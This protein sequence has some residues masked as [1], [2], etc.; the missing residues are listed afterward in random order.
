[1]ANYHGDFLWYELMSSDREAAEAFYAPLT[2]WKFGSDPAYRHIEASEGHI[3]GLL[4]LTDEMCSHG[5][6]P[7]WLGYIMVDDTDKMAASIEADGGRVTMP[8]RDIEGAGRIAMVTD[9][10]GAHFYVMTPKPPEGVEDPE[11]H[12]FSYDRPRMGHCAWNELSTSDPDAAKRFY[13]KHFGWV[14]DGEMDMGPLGKYEF[15]RHAGRAPDGSPMGHGVLGAVM[16]LMPGGAPMPVWTFYFRVPDID[17]AAETINTGGG[18]LI[19]EP[20]EIP[21]GDY[22]LVA[23]DPQGASFGLVGPRKGT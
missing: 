16:P 7:G 10:Q 11:V 23:A 20:V 5:A 3:G 18:S 2:G 22:S 13:G 8:A 1:M 4:Q 15:L 12:A 17:A 9:P 21:G 19:Q 14:K 6:R